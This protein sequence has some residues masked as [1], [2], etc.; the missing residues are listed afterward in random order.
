MHRVPIVAV[1][2]EALSGCRE[3]CLAA[4]MDDFIPKPVNLAVLAEAVRKWRR[5]C[6]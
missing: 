6:E 2:A 3:E 1:T 4:G 5:P